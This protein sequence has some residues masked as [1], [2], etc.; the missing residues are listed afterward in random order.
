[1]EFS[2]A[3]LLSK[4]KGAE[5]QNDANLQHFVKIITYSVAI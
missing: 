2:Y 5:F 1:M 3:Q 4:R